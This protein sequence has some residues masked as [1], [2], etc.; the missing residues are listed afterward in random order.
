MISTLSRPDRFNCNRHQCRL[1]FKY[2]STMAS[3]KA[4]P[5][6]PPGLRRERIEDWPFGSLGNKQGT[7]SKP[8]I[9]IAA[10][11]PWHR[12]SA[13]IDR[14][15]ELFSR[16][17]TAGRRPRSLNSERLGGPCEGGEGRV[18]DRPLDFWVSR[19]ARCSTWQLNERLFV[20]CSGSVH[21][22]RSNSNEGCVSTRSQ[23]E[24]EHRNRVGRARL[25]RT[26]R[27]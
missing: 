19:Y 24:E 6:R 4:G 7:Q 22:Q 25:V 8:A 27:P 23:S 13:E 12:N 3:G 18:G 20:S 1:R 21:L 14:I 11:E 26:G 5:F 9:A 15:V 17:A 10:M 16:F 2:R